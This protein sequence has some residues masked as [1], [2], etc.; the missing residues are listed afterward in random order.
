MSHSLVMTRDEKHCTVLAYREKVTYW[1]VQSID[2]P[3]IVLRR[4]DSER[5]YTVR[6]VVEPLVYRATL[7]A[8]SRRVQ[9]RGV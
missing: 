1:M 9:P 2:L 8:E 3:E 4:G 6:E 7:T 5:T